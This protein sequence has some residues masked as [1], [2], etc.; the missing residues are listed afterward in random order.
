VRNKREGV[1]MHIKFYKEKM[2]RITYL[3]DLAVNERII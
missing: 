3:E 2:K 1:K